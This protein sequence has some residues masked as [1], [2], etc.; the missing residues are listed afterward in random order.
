MDVIVEDKP[1][2]TAAIDELKIPFCVLSC[3]PNNV[4]F[5]DNCVFAFELLIPVE[6]YIN[7][8]Q[9]KLEI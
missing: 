8:I 7:T 6:D 9:F 1:T 5:V 2:V 3:R 4:E